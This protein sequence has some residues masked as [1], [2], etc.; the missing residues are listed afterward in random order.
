MTQSLSRLCFLANELRQPLPKWLIKYLP[1]GEII[2]QIA[3]TGIVGVNLTEEIELDQLKGLVAKGSQ[4]GPANSVEWRT[5][6]TQLALEELEEQRDFLSED[7]FM[8]AISKL[9]EFKKGGESLIY[10]DEGTWN[11]EGTEIP[12]WNTGIEPLDMIQQG[13]YQGVF[14]LMAP[15]G[16]GKTSKMLRLAAEMRKNHVADEIWH[17]QLEIPKAMLQ[18]RIGPLRDELKANKTPFIPGKDRIFYGLRPFSEVLHEVQ[19]HPNPD[20]VIFYDSPDVLAA[21]M[22]EDRRLELG[23]IYR[24][25]V[26]LK[27][28]CKAIFVAS[29]PRR[30]DSNKK[31][32]MESV[33]EAWEKAWYA[34]GILGFQRLGM[35]SSRIGIYRAAVLKNRFGP[36]DGEIRYNFDLINLSMTLRPDSKVTTSAGWDDEENW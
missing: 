21:A 19:L 11:E 2:Q 9:V 10:L 16:T 22:G 5:I 6:V 36:P 27:Q 20:R 8:R 32:V 13:F 7:D 1:Q 35:A 34:D 25:L 30:R 3:Q 23:S 26:Q 15:P 24:D 17:Y 14:I 28:Y 18:Y 31:L 4:L 29:Q 33:S 12:K